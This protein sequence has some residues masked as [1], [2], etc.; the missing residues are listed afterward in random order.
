MTTVEQILMIKGPDVIVADPTTT[1]LEA[2][3]LMTENNVGSI[4]IR[5]DD[6]AKGIFTERDLM[7]RVVAVLKDPATLQISEVMSS[8]VRSCR[9]SDD[10]HHCGGL[11]AESHIRHLAVVEDGTLVGLISLRDIQ[12]A[13]IHEDE[14]EIER[15]LYFTKRMT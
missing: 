12:T 8:P 11:F 10:I 2:A 3:R 15:L 9:L 7:Q 6:V 1:V 4:V 14:E 5:E 13:E